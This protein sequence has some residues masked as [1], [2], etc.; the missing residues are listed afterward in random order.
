MLDDRDNSSLFILY[1]PVVHNSKLFII[2]GTEGDS[3]HPNWM[4]LLPIVY[5]SA[6]GST[7]TTETTPFPVPIAYCAAVSF[8]SKV[9]L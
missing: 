4:H 8:G 6:D 9:R 3:T 5:S 2:G 7:W 1:H